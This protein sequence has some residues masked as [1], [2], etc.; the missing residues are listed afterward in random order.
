M[1]CGGVSCTCLV[2]WF[3]CSC[4]QTGVWT[5]YF[6]TTPFRL[7]SVHDF[8]FFFAFYTIR[9]DL[10]VGWTIGVRLPAWAL[11]C[12]LF[13]TNALRRTRSPGR[14]MWIWLSVTSVPRLM[15]CAVLRRIL[16]GLMTPN[17]G[18]QST[19]SVSL[20]TVRIFPTAMWQSKSDAF[21]QI[22]I[23]KQIVLV[24]GVHLNNF[25]VLG[26]I[27]QYCC[28]WFSLPRPQYGFK[29]V[30]RWDSWFFYF[31]PSFKFI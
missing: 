10:A 26:C 12:S 13:V 18:T 22:S 31:R 9:S 15:C 20:Y 1:R 3:A 5:E 2:D 23:N 6:T 4:L 11:H 25:G 21:L 17:L 27:P 7:G 24:Y 8:V 19:F 16:N 14:H 29:S 30:I 28:L